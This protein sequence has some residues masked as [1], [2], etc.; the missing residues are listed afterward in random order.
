[1]HKYK[2]HVTY[3][4]RQA[5]RGPSEDILARLISGVFSSETGPVTIAIGGP[6]GTGKSTFSAKLAALL[7]DCTI[8][9][10]DDYKTPRHI[11]KGRNLFG[12]HP[13]ANQMDLAAEHISLI[14][15]N[16]PFDKPVYNSVTGQAD[17]T[18]PFEPRR[19][20][21]LDGEIS[22]Y[23]DFRDD[24]DFSIFIDSDYKT[25][26][27]TRTTRDIVSRQYT[28]DKA[29][30]TFLQSNLRE[31]T[32]YGAESKNWA[33]VH[34]YC[35]EDY[36]LFIESV[37]RELYEHFESLLNESLSAVDLTGLVVP[38]TTPFDEN[39]KI[40]KRMFIEHLDMLA[41]Q[42]VKRILVNGTTAEFFS[43][44]QDERKVCLKL[45][46]EYFP[47]VIMFHAG[48]SSFKQTM[49]EA[50]WGRQY[51]ADAIVCIVP[52]YMAGI[53][54]T[55]IVDYF[56]ALEKAIDIPLILYNFP[57]HTGNSLDADMIARIKHFGMKD[58]S[59]D[60]SLVSA[61]ENYYMGGDEKILAAYGKG[62]CG[63]VS[64]RANAFAPLLVEMEAALVRNDES[65]Q[66]LQD[67]ITNLKENTAGPNGIARLKYAVAA[68]LK[69][70]PER[71]RLPL[72]ELSDAEKIIMDKAIKMCKSYLIA[73]R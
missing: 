55:G 65:V 25:Q 45:A 16:T 13:D 10:L 62:A 72:V 33:D 28:W 32:M 20:N 51:G 15:K 70:Y 5:R 27:A 35:K 44:T 39:D 21:I 59:G 37:A 50:K 7:D 34:I 60:L 54:K 68:Q 9:R 43:M 6:G 24:V 52:Y 1:M 46:R 40:D 56:N 61:T 36:T 41:A 69:G 64:A 53:D 18:E 4:G 47:G 71:V 3:K 14:K 63:F 57:K 42:G 66:P 38:V 31:F 2:T 58:S 19:F 17:K 49:I 67:K 23:R 22:T 11:R 30:E 12:A 29:I 48:C 26:L 8:L 73:N